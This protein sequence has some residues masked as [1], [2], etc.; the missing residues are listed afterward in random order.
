MKG[1]KSGMKNKLIGIFFL[2]INIFLLSSCNMS[3]LMADNM[4]N[5]PNYHSTRFLNKFTLDEVPYNEVDKMP[6]IENAY[7]KIFKDDNKIIFYEDESTKEIILAGTILND[8]VFSYK[9]SYLCLLFNEK[10]YIYDF[11]NDK[12]IDLEYDLNDYYNMHLYVINQNLYL[13]GSRKNE[14]D[15]F[16]LNDEFDKTLL[17]NIEINTIE[18]IM[19]LYFWKDYY[20]I[21]A[22]NYEYETNCKTNLS[23]I[24][25]DNQLNIINGKI[26]SVKKCDYNYDYMKKKIVFFEQ[27]LFYSDD[28]LESD[29]YKDGHEA[30]NIYKDIY[31]Y[32]LYKQNSFIEIDGYYK[33]C[34]QVA[35][36][37]IYYY[38]LTDCFENEDKKS[39]GYYVIRFNANNGDFRISDFNISDQIKFL[40]QVGNQIQ[41]KIESNGNLT[42][43]AYF[44]K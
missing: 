9:N 41:L 43:I 33:R 24:E 25:I 14:T 7:Y 3:L 19:F 36:K 4:N 44:I 32:G 17:Y 29:Y 42:N 39:T 16:E 20:I 37:N 11:T 12:Y 26:Y 2:F 23:K 35:Y 31:E 15:I 27:K 30:E 34:Y 38:I 28:S 5:N 13:I 8:K 40:K 6:L 1:V 21:Q 18:G 22:A 10:Y